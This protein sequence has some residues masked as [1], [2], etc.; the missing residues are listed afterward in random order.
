M[1]HFK[2]QTSM[3][4]LILLALLALQGLSG[5]LDAQTL[6]LRVRDIPKAEGHLYVAFYAS[7]ADFLKKPLTG[8]R[9]AVTDTTLVIPCRGLLAGEYTFALFQDTNGNGRLDTAAFGIPTEKYAFSNDAE[10]V[11]GPPSYD[12]C[13]FRLQSDT[14]MIVRLR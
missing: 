11:M 10:A 6:T 4:T 13:R 3:K 9:V 5:A 12:K 8:F 1:I 7:E 14:T 2:K